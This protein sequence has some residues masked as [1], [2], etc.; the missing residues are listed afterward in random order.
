MTVAVYV[1]GKFLV[2]DKRSTGGYRGLS[3]NEKKIHTVKDT[4][5]NLTHV[6][7][8]GV[9]MMP[10]FIE[11]LVKKHF[12]SMEAKK[13][14]RSERLYKFRDEISPYIGENWE[15]IIVFV[16]YWSNCSIDAFKM[17]EKQVTEIKE[18]CA[19]GSGGYFAE[20][21]YLKDNDTPPE[22][23]PFLISKREVTVGPD[24]DIINF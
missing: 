23:Y 20:G 10:A 7:L 11:V 1:P 21:I 3:N 18:F 12:H 8:A 22:D 14:D 19:I 6:V 24:S 9:A 16:K 2:A 17:T 5:D 4:S 15:G 13:L